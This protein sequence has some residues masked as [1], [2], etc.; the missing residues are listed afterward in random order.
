M[1]ISLLIL[2]PFLL[3]ISHYAFANVANSDTYNISGTFFNDVNKNGLIDYSEVGISGIKL[4][5]ED[6]VV[7]SDENGKY[8]INKKV[9][10]NFLKVIVDN[11]SLPSS[12]IVNGPSEFLIYKEHNI[13][14]RK[15][16]A[17]IL[18]EDKSV[19]KFQDELDELGFIK[20]TKESTL[21]VDLKNR[22]IFINNHFYSKF[23]AHPEMKNISFNYDPL[24]LKP[25][26]LQESFRDFITDFKQNLSVE[27][28][29]NNEDQK[30]DE[31]LK[32]TI[33][34]LLDDHGLKAENFKIIFKTG[35]EKIRFSYEK[36][37]NFCV[38]HFNKEKKIITNTSTLKIKFNF[39]SDNNLYFDCLKKN[40]HLP[41]IKFTTMKKESDYVKNHMKDNNL[42]LPFVHSI[43]NK[44]YL[45]DHE[46]EKVLETDIYK[47]RNIHL[48]IKDNYDVKYL[49]PIDIK[50][51]KVL[52]K[53]MAH[54][55]GELHL[56]Y[57]KH[58]NENRDEKVF[59]RLESKNI[60]E[61]RVNGQLAKNPESF[62]YTQD[63]HK[64][65]NT[66][67]IKAINKKGQQKDFKFK[68]KIMEEPKIRMAM[69]L[70]LSEI[71]STTERFDTKYDLKQ[72]KNLGAHFQYFH[73]N[74]WGANIISKINVSDIDFQRFSGGTANYNEKDLLIEVLYRKALDEQKYNSNQFIFS[75]GSFSKF[76]TLTND[77][78]E[79]FYPQNLY[80]IS[81][82]VEYFDKEF[83]FEGIT[84]RSK[85]IYG[86]GLD[87]IDERSIHITQEF[88]VSF[89]IMGKYLGFPSYYSYDYQYKYLK[90][91]GGYLKLRYDKS[92]RRVANFSGETMDQIERVASIGINFHY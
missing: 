34:L 77:D 61:V 18:D 68:Y 67:T 4:K 28:F 91:L 13:F 88:E 56:Y 64:G 54:D 27:I 92:T 24:T 50:R 58:L 66:L 2:L 35:E 38:A 26:I 23:E 69:D 47:E 83:L 12:A 20:I 3:G 33:E 51:P 79:F 40:Y 59:F 48:T 17:I 70:G 31:I 43:D 41:Y 85:L 63:A 39:E 73:D 80:M 78:V 72:I 46:I 55:N 74:H 60:Q 5:V 75:V 7:Y 57:S 82:G 71:T 14:V 65:Q 42:I 52:E 30:K 76:V 36:E 6:D 32:G 10:G 22:S 8:E 15:D 89:N 25:R 81:G 84:S 11:N 62:S 45:Y 44:V 16:F 1:K 9:K 37:D 90:N 87:H 21:D 49:I 29:R 19:F 53:I 86:I